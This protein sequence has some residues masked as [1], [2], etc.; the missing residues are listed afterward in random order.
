MWISLKLFLEVVIKGKSNSWDARIM[1]Y[2]SLVTTPNNDL[3]T[4]LDT[5]FW[6][7]ETFEDDYGYEI[8][9]KVFRVF[10]KYRLPG[11]RHFNMFHFKS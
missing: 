3:L 4:T 8:W 11:K 7:L 2:D 10:L 1:F 9:L 5:S 6:L